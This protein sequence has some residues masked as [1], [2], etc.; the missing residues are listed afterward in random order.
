MQLTK[1]VVVVVVMPP[2][3]GVML[4]LWHLPVVE[5]QAGQFTSLG[6]CF[7]T[8]QTGKTTAPT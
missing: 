6:L 7:L 2:L 1:L 3:S 5:L 4:Y 8:V